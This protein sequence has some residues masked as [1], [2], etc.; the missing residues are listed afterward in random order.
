MKNK[1][2][3]VGEQKQRKSQK[4]NEADSL[5]VIVCHFTTTTTTTTKYGIYSSDFLVAFTQIR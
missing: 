4:S 1:A 2:D 3:T 5:F